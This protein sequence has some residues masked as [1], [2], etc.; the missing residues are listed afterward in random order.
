[1]FITFEGLDGSGKTTQA[2]LL[3]NQLNALKMQVIYTR[4][5]GGTPL[6]EGIRNLVLSNNI[7]DPITEFLLLSAA[8]RDHIYQLIEPAIDEGK[9][10]ICDRFLDSSLLYQGYCKG[11]PLQLIREIHSKAVDGVM[12][13]LTIIVD[14][15]VEMALK[16][17]A[18]RS[19]DIST[20]HYDQRD[21]AFYKTIYEGLH[22]LARTEPG[23]F[24]IVDGT[25]DE[26][27]VAQHI[28]E[29]VCQAAANVGFCSRKF[30][31]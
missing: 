12:P 30:K 7:A 5:P 6:A 22:S 21:R 1:M 10:V 25:Q 17:V 29:I 14:V 28:L 16:R 4:E 3:T 19:T 24:V 15:P 31:R 13:N 26:H 11:M 2:K 8:R 20:N 23:R 9:I 27:T 18:E